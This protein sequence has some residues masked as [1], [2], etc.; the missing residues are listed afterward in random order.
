MEH[1][2]DKFVDYSFERSSGF[3][4]YWFRELMAKTAVTPAA[5]K[6]EQQRGDHREW[7]TG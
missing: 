4:L 6:D 5:A 1:R 2:A 3:L 7:I